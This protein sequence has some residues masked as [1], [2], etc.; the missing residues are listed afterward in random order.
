MRLVECPCL[1]LSATIGNAENLQSF[2]SSVRQQ[3]KDCIPFLKPPG[4][5]LRDPNVHLE[6][7][8]VRNINMQRLILNPNKELIAKFEKFPFVKVE[9]AGKMFD[10]VPLH[11]CSAVDVKTIRSKSFSELNISF[12][13]RDSIALWSV[14]DKFIQDKDGIAHLEPVTFFSQFGNSDKHQITLAQVIII[15]PFPF[16]HALSFLV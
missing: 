16:F 13:P 3:H 8:D 2:W 4:D 5:E 15:S 1:A 12:T 6:E 11:P 7:I 10:L 9:D 14:L